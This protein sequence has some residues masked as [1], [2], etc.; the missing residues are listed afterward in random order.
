[1]YLKIFKLSKKNKN[2]GS[3]NEV[4]IYKNEQNNEK[5]DGRKIIEISND[6]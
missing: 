5:I 1:M 2:N 3:N 4:K 6:K